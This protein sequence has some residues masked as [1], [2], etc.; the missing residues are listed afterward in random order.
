M[1][2]S[3]PTPPGGDASRTAPIA[4]WRTVVL[5]MVA[6]VVLGI[7]LRLLFGSASSVITEIRTGYGLGS[8]EVALLTTGPVVCLGLG[9][10]LAPRLARRFRAL[11]VAAGAMAVLAVGS[12]L[13]AVP[14]WP[15][16]LVA[17]MIGGLGIA[18]ANVLGPVLIRLLFPHRIG[19]MTGLL[20]ALIC[21]SAGIASGVT[22]PL[23]RAVGDSWRLALGVWAVPALL[24]AIAM[25][26]L[27]VVHG[28]G[29]TRVAAADTTTPAR[30]VIARPGEARMRWAI[31]GFMGI[32]S[33]LAYA[34]VAWLPTIYRD[35]GL[36]ADEAGLIFLAL[37]VSSIVTAL[38][39]P[40]LATRMRSQR[41]LALGVVSLAVI[42]LL[43]VLCTGTGGA[44]PCAIIVGL[45]QGG[46]L[47]LALVLM[48]LRSASA[49]EATALSASAQ[50]FG[51]LLAAIGPLAMGL[52]HSLTGGWSVPLIA[53]TATMVP[54]AV[55]GVIAGHPGSYGAPED[56]LPVAVTDAR[57]PIH[58]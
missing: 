38:T 47:S 1:S 55:C 46:A 3:T 36:S 31:T 44:W 35:R 4:P 14:S 39:V 5:A 26:A 42:G 6:I 33:L 50:T 21:V 17:T 18:V 30:S 10:A 15:I 53:L 43:G 29:R 25:T 37:S 9:A 45:G 56:D 58:S 41:L 24:A 27:A 51:Y 23:T 32:Q 28:R 57:P 2:R 22:P 11:P 7:S 34:T 52:L 40:V 48:N 54:L 20:T 12:A 8:V 49:A 16:L 13:R 19:A